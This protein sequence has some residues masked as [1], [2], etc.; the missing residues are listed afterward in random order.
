M[1]I[2]INGESKE[3]PGPG[4]PRTVADLLVHLTLPVDRVAVEV[5]GVVVRKSDR[6]A[7]AIAD[8]DV[9]EIVTLVGGG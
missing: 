3:L 9:F 7:H 6:A 4:A 2:T 1:R 8:G 5:N